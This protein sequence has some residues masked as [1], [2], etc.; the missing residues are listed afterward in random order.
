MTWSKI[1]SRVGDCC[2]DAAHLLDRL[3]PAQGVDDRLRRDEPVCVRRAGERLLQR[4]PE[5]VGEA[6]RSGVG[7]RVVERDR[8]GSSRSIAAAAGGGDAL[9]VGDDLA[10]GIEVADGGC[11]E[12]SDDGDALAVRSD[13]ERAL[14]GAV[15]AGDQVEAR[16]LRQQRLAH[17]REP[18]VD[19]LL[20]EDLRRLVELLVDEHVRRGQ[21]RET[22][23]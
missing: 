4:E 7:G 19:V 14:P 1:S 17:E 8:A 13:E 2:T 21:G 5:P 12:A 16:V 15:R 18:E 9:V 10:V 20:P 22:S 6:V 3:P 23:R 11:V